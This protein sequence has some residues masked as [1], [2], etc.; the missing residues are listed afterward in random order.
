MNSR[1]EPPNDPPPLTGRQ[2]FFCW[3]FIAVFIVVMAWLTMGCK[4]LDRLDTLAKVQAE[5]Q[6]EIVGWKSNTNWALDHINAT[7]GGGVDS[8]ALWLSIAALGVSSVA[9]PVQRA[10]RLRAQERKMRALEKVVD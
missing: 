2:M 6:T 1:Y 3:F 7:V 4:A 8:I 5:M 9:Y 10:L